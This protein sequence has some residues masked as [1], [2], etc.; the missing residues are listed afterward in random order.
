MMEKEDSFYSQVNYRVFVVN[1]WT[2]VLF[3]VIDRLVLPQSA[4]FLNHIGMIMMGISALA[5][6]AFL[7]H[8]HR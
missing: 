8:R 4:P 2:G 3:I 7:L 5:L 1:G 6:S